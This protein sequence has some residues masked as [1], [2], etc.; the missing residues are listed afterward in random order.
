M[1]AERPVARW[2][3]MRRVAC[4]VL[5]GATVAGCAVAGPS[6][7]CAPGAG[8]PMIVYELFFGRTID[9]RDSPV[10]D[11]EWNAFVAQVVTPNLPA[12]FTV[13]NGQGQWQNPATTEIVRDPTKILIVAAPST[14]QTAGAIKTIRQA[15]EQRFGQQ[16]VGMTSHGACGDFA[17]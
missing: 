2:R 15:Y 3:W 6:G 17:S 4:T 10:S 13:L 14:R 8:S 12:G 9:G 7:D 5:L 1:M 11:A 16:S